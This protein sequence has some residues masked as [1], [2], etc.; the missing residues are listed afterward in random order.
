ML[1]SNNILL[2]LA[3]AITAIISNCLFK[4][5]IE[6]NNFF[7]Q[8]SILRLMEDLIR[9]LLLPSM[10]VGISFFILSNVLWIIIVSSQKMGLAYPLHIGLCFVFILLSSF[11]IFKENFMLSHFIGISLIVSGI[12]IISISGS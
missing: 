8:G 12:I 2:N 5:S 6:K 4:Y 9:L 3:C 10:W 1:I 11:F 7:W